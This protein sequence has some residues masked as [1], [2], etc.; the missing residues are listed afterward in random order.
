MLAAARSSLAFSLLV[1][2]ISAMMFVP[3]AAA[4]HIEAAPPLPDRPS[5]TSTLYAVLF[6]DGAE[7]PDGSLFRLGWACTTSGGG[8]DDFTM[9]GDVVAAR[10]ARGDAAVSVL[11]QEGGEGYGYGYTE[12]GEGYGYGYGYGYGLGI[13]SIGFEVT[14]DAATFAP[15]ERCT[16]TAALTG[17]PVVSEPSVPFVPRPVGGGGSAPGPAPAPAPAQAPDASDPGAPGPAG[18]S[19]AGLGPAGADGPERAPERSILRDPKTWII[20]GVGLGLASATTLGILS[21][22]RR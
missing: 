2:G 3:L 16:A 20:G 15:N 1:T 4:E 12:P 6:L 17:R 14:L 9:E 8:A 18:S 22:L 11:Y 13:A 21:L 19:V 10:H 5:G 7:W